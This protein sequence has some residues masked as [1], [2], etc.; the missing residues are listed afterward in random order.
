M[1][2]IFEFDKGE[3]FGEAEDKLRRQKEF[4][5]TFADNPEAEEEIDGCLAQARSAL[6]DICDPRVYVKEV[7]LCNDGD[8]LLFGAARVENSP[9]NEAFDEGATALA[10]LLT[11]SYDSKAML[12]SLDNDYVIYHFQHVLGREVLFALGRAV[13]KTI[14]YRFGKKFKRHSIRMR[15]EEVEAVSK[16]EKI[17]YWDPQVVASLLSN[18]D[19]CNCGIRVNE[20]GCFD[21]L[22]TILGIMISADS[23]EIK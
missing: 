6:Y 18:F 5:K 20:S 12:Q 13:H 11:L 1:D 3:L 4:T 19:D 10:Y 17:N 8:A 9:L 23:K 7:S 21:P 15:K 14:N 22:Q 16:D 2:S